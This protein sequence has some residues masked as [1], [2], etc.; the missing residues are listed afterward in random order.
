MLRLSKTSKVQR[1][2][3]YRD[4]YNANLSEE[5]TINADGLQLVVLPDAG[6]DDETEFEDEEED[7]EEEEDTV[8]DPEKK[9]IMQILNCVT[10]TLACVTAYIS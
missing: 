10:F 4:T 9:M 1:T 8:V 7:E 3:R 5:Q 6:G 2:A